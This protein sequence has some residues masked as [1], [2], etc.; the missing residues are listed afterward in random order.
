MGA[1]KQE[2]KAARP[3][4]RAAVKTHSEDGVD[5]KMIRQML[6]RTPAERLEFLQS[7]ARAMLKRGPIPRS[8]KQKFKLGQ[9]IMRRA[10]NE[11]TYK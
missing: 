4:R 9:E 3:K 2:M 6:S 5:V 11:K 1:R 10:L 8:E 7:T